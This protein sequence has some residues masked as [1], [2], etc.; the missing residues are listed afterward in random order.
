MGGLEVINVSKYYKER[1]VL[2]RI[3][4]ST[5]NK[6]FIGIIGQSGAGKS[7]LLRIIAGLEVPDAGF[8]RID[9][10]K[11]KGPTQYVGYLFQDYRLFPWLTVKENVFFPI[12][13]SGLKKATA[14][15]LYERALYYMEILGLTEKC[16]NYPHELSGGLK[17]RVALCRSLSLHPKILL[18][19]EPSSALDMF[20][21]IK[22]WILL[23]KLY[24]EIDTTFIVVSHN[25]DEVAF[26]CDRVIVLD[27]HPGRVLADIRIDQYKSKQD[28]IVDVNYLFSS[29]HT[30]IK[31]IIS[32]MLF[33]NGSPNHNT[34]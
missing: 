10:E 3:D 6:E 7:T 18:L 2:D 1:L 34:T 11:V 30:R 29:G 15:S 27:S 26:L 33:K 5:Y 28:E 16:N 19:D 32:D 22:S 17:Q 21:A 13:N 23:R 9:G 14:Y 12:D 8:I 31:K 24:E 25:L 4:I 20:T